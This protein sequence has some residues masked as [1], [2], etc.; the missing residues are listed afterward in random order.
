MPGS[1]PQ[2]GREMDVG[3]LDNQS[4]FEYHSEGFTTGGLA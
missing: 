3:R 4:T 1:L 2:R